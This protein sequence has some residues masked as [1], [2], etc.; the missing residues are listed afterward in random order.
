MMVSFRTGIL[1]AVILL[2]GCAN[3]VA[4]TS[5]HANLDEYCFKGTLS[6]T[7]REY[8][9]LAADSSMGGPNPT[10]KWR[11][12]AELQSGGPALMDS[13]LVGLWEK[14]RLASV[15][16]NDPELAARLAPA[17]VG[18][19][20][21]W[22]DKEVAQLLATYRAETSEDQIDN[23]VT[24]LLGQALGWT[25]AQSERALS[26]LQSDDEY[27]L[28]GVMVR[29]IHANLRGPF[30]VDSLIKQLVEQGTVKS[31]S[32]WDG[33]GVRNLESESWSATVTIPVRH[34]EAEQY[35]HSLLRV[36]PEGNVEFDHGHA[37][38]LHSDR[39]L[40]ALARQA[41]DELGWPLPS[42]PPN[43]G[44]TSQVKTGCPDD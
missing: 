34:F 20:T 26:K 18:T 42:W 31:P 33:F 35:G 19:P 13:S 17:G 4:P 21:L 32:P 29:P 43:P 5:W 44:Y 16:W 30:D 24:K 37:R 39:D 7:Q 6:W 1:V 27:V 10:T 38:L 12:A 9:T 14:P 36:D 41:T 15:T 3:P 11:Y 22:F 40:W 28:N 23:D 25:Q 8:A 2:A